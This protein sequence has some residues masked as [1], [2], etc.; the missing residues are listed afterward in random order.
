MKLKTKTL[1][2]EPDMR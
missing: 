1:N 2:S